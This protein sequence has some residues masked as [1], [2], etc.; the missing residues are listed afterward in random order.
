MKVAA[1]RSSFSKTGLRF[2]I[3]GL[4]LR[5]RIVSLQNRKPKR[6]M[7][8]KPSGT[9]MPTPMAVGRLAEC[10]WVGPGVGDSVDMSVDCSWVCAATEGPVKVLTEEAAGVEIGFELGLAE[11]EEVVVTKSLELLVGSDDEGVRGGN[12]KR[13]PLV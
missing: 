11:S 12:P 4:S 3:R 5:C 6:P 9:P 1:G 8:A 10:F 13:L 7:T 2:G